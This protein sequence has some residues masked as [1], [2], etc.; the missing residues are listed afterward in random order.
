MIRCLEDTDED[1]DLFLIVDYQPCPCKALVDP[2]GHES[3]VLV[4]CVLTVAKVT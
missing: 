2:R 4:F 3:P 1:P